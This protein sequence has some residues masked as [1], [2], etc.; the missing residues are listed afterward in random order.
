MPTRPQQRDWRQV[1][2][3]SSEMVIKSIIKDDRK[4]SNNSNHM[5]SSMN[6]DD[7]MEIEEAQAPPKRHITWHT[8]VAVRETLHI[9]DFT[10][11]EYEKTWFKREDFTRIKAALAKTVRKVAANQPIDPETETARGLEYRCVVKLK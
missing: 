2:E 3:H 11:E 7:M 9:N 6:L 10:D 8:S 5:N 1:E 4:S